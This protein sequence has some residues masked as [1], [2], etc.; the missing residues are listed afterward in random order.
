MKSMTSVYKYS[1][2]AMDY[3]VDCRGKKG[4][5]DIQ[6][7]PPLPVCRLNILLYTSLCADWIFLYMSLCEHWI[8]LYTSLCADWIFLYTSLCAD[9]IFSCI[10]PCVQTEYSELFK[11]NRR[12]AEESTFTDLKYVLSFNSVLYW[13]HMMYDLTFFTFSVYKYIYFCPF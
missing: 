4:G 12:L 13:S 6:V 11:K 9:W 2:M 10:R 8:F 3:C 7:N 1:N 5:R